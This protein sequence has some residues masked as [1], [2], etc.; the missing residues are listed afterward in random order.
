MS[1]HSPAAVSTCRRTTVTSCL[2]FQLFEKNP[3]VTTKGTV[4][5]VHLS[6]AA[7]VTRGHTSLTEFTASLVCTAP[8]QHNLSLD[9]SA[10]CQS[11]KNNAKRS[12]R[13]VRALSTLALTHCLQVTALPLVASCHKEL[14]ISNASQADDSTTKITLKSRNS[15][16][17]R[18]KPHGICVSLFLVCLPEHHTTFRL[19]S[20]FRIVA[21][22]CRVHHLSAASS[23]TVRRDVFSHAMH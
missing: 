9:S 1:Q 13:N 11:D 15:P 23:P 3:N 14:E 19:Y 12:R 6:I 21:K 7:L 22:N 17:R 5:S 20:A 16:P 18:R 2:K 8:S 4:R 10:T